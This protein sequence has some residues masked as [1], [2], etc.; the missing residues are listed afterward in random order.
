MQLH[1]S[2]WQTSIDNMLFVHFLYQVFIIA[3]HS[4][5]NNVWF[6]S[7]IGKSVADHFDFF[8]MGY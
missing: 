5:V 6:C 7:V 8:E 3:A 1:Y 4:N 2:I